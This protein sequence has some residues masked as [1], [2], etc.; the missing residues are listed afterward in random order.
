MKEDNS[1]LIQRIKNLEQHFKDYPNDKFKSNDE[2]V[3]KRN[4]YKQI[5]K[6]QFGDTDTNLHMYSI[7]Y[8]EYKIFKYILAQKEYEQSQTKVDKALNYIGSI[9]PQHVSGR[10]YRVE[11]GDGCAKFC[12]WFMVIDGLILLL[13]YLMGVI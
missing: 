13:L 1:V 9:T 11:N 10:I 4:A 3:K 8:L 2:D 12:F 6:S 5:L 7:K